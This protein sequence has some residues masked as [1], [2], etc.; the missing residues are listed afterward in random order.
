[1]RALSVKQPW[2][3]LIVSGAKDIENRTWCVLNRL[4]LPMRIYIHASKTEDTYDYDSLYP[5][6][7]DLMASLDFT[8]GAIIGEVTITGCDLESKSEWYEGPHGFSLA[9]AEQYDVPIPCKGSL[10][11]W[12]PPREVIHG[13]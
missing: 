2:A 10:G 5:R 4:S 1:M 9:L 6:Y 13:R 3:S 8:K 11:F 12:T 7:P